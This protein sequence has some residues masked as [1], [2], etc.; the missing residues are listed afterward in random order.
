MRNAAAAINSQR[1][2]MPEMTRDGGNYVPRILDEVEL[3]TSA[4]LRLRLGEAASMRCGP[5]R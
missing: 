1:A 5:R 3:G 4:T 2:L